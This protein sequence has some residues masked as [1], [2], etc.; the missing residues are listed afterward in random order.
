MLKKKKSKLLNFVSVCYKIRDILLNKIYQFPGK[1]VS[2]KSK[3]TIY[4]LLFSSL[5]M[6]DTYASQNHFNTDE[7]LKVKAAFILNLARFVEWPESVNYN[8]HKDVVVCF[9]QYDFLK[10][11]TNTLLDK[12]INKKPIK[13]KIV[14][15]F[16]VTED[17]KV[18]LI[19]VSALSLFV[20]HNDFKV[21]QNK[22]T[23]TDLS[24]D[25]INN[26]V[27]DK[28]GF[29]L[30]NKVIFRLKREKLRLRFEVN[31]IASERLGIKIGSELLKLG[32]L[33]QDQELE[34]DSHEQRD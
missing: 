11:A 10:R 18:I 33:V 30:E 6:F 24:S 15:E 23:I 21:L 29:S 9:Y 32:I 16:R 34:Q 31:K 4:S 27:D 3:I 2:I 8:G 19:P 26:R 22:I 12:K 1:V 28:S 7:Q 17:C 14:N 20:K 25:D 5:L 13:I